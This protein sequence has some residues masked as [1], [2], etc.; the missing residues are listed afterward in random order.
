MKWLAAEGR[1]WRLRH[2]AR[3]R[4][5][6]RTGVPGKKSNNH[7]PRLRAACSA[8][9]GDVPAPHRR[10]GWRLKAAP[11][12]AGAGR[13]WAAAR[14]AQPRVRAPSAGRREP[15]Q[16]AR[17]RTPSVRKPSKAVGPQ[18]PLPAGAAPLAAL[19]RPRLE[20]APP[21][22]PTQAKTNDDVLTAAARSVRKG[23]WRAATRHREGP[24]DSPP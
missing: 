20:A 7:Q 21:S 23:M 8:S 14:E 18:G 3:L 10:G 5:L 13:R 17:V 16:R 2:E 11:A 15:A 24:Q 4:G 6:G 1:A 12:A 9:Q 19:V 22:P